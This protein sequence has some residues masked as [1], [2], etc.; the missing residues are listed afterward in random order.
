MKLAPSKEARLPSKNKNRQQGDF[1]LS[2]RFN[3]M[4]RLQRG[5]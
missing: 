1:S 4:R 2:L 3:S 5:T